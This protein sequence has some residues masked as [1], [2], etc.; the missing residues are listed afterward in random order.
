MLRVSWNK[1]LVSLQENVNKTTKNKEPKHINVR[2]VVI[3][4]KHSL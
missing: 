4:D 1:E 3:Q 2:H